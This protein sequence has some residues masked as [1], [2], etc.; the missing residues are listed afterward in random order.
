MSLDIKTTIE[1]A[2]AIK[3]LA[4]LY[5]LAK[6]SLSSEEHK[7]LVLGAS[8]TGKSTMVAHLRDKEPAD[9]STSATTEYK[10]YKCGKSVLL[11]DTPGHG[12]LEHDRTQTVKE[13]STAKRL[14]VINV[15]ACGYHEPLTPGSKSPRGKDG[16]PPGAYLKRMRELEMKRLQ[17]FV[18]MLIRTAKARPPVITVVNKADLWWTPDNEEDVLK[19]YKQSEY[20]EGLNHPDHYV[21]PG[22]FCTQRFFGKFPMKGYVGDEERARF[23]HLL[24]EVLNSCLKRKD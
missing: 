23:A 22:C 24:G 10:A 15:V 20:S 4:D 17:D 12:T 1:A 21:I 11:V 3:G 8:G 18:P 9:Q 6:A 7:V 19:S 13:A 14:I 2:K 16:Q 5:V